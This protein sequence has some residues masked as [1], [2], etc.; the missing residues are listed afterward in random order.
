VLG[1]THYPFL[2]PLIE[3]AAL[4]AGGLGVKII[5]TGEAVARLL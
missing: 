4:R 1:C 2:L 5:D 3:E